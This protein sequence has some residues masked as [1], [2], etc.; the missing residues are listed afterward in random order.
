MPFSTKKKISYISLICL[1][2]SFFPQY[3]IVIWINHFLHIDAFWHLC[4]RRLFENM[5]TKELIAQNEHVLFLSP[6]FQLL[7]FHLK[8]VSNCFGYVFKVVCCSYVVSGNGWRKYITQRTKQKL[9]LNTQRAFTYRRNTPLP[10]CIII[11]I[12]C[13]IIFSVRLC[14][15]KMIL[16]LYQDSKWKVT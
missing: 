6:C 5:A 9:P 13:L 1:Y 10:S 3:L 7:F 14:F 11:T 15:V 4:S 16:I 12:K 8:G 2:L